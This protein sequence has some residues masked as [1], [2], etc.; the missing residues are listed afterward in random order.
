MSKRLEELTVGETPE[1]LIA[2][3]EKK[4][5]LIFRQEEIERARWN[6]YSTT[7][8]FLGDILVFQ[9]DCLGLATLGYRVAGV[10]VL[11]ID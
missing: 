4:Y 2:K 9:S 5:N 7:N 8:E 10:S 1:D 6:V 11:K 3:L